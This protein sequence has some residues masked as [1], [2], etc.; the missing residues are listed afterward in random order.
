MAVT[1]GIALNDISTDNNSL[2][3]NQDLEW[4]GSIARASKQ[5]AKFSL[6]LAM[7]EQNI[8]LRPKVKSPD[9]NTIEPEPELES[10]YRTPALAA[11][12]EHFSSAA[13]TNRILHQQTLA[14][15]LLWQAMHPDP[16]ALQA[17][18]EHI[19]EAII[20]NMSF[21]AQNQYRRPVDREVAPNETQLYDLLQQLGPE[22]ESMGG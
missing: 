21:H 11:Q 10:F 6:L 1:Q 5:G 7:L 3:I 14:D 20:S 16:L 8:L 9:E 17:D 4:S 12:A 15:A 2:A 18:S 22:A 13:T 19:E